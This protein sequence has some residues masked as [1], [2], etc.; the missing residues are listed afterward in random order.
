MRPVRPQ[1]PSA[2]AERLVREHAGEH[3][4]LALLV[5]AVLAQRG[6]LRALAR[7][8]AEL[9]RDGAEAWPVRRAAT[10]IL[11]H[12]LLRTDD[13][14]EWHWWMREL[15]VTGIDAHHLRAR[16][17]RLA[18]VH[19]SIATDT[20]LGDFLHIAARDC[21]LTLARYTFGAK[22]VVAQIERDLRRS[23]GL[24]SKPDYGHHLVYE[25]ADH[26]LSTLAPMDRAIIEHLG[27]DATIR[28]T[29]ER[30]SDDINT[31]VEHP[32]G[33]VV[34][35]IKPPGSDIEIEIKRAGVRESFP[36]DVVFSRGGYIVPN[37]H[38]LHG[39]SMEHLLAFETSQASVLSRLYRSVHGTDA[40][41]SRTIHLATVYTIPTP[42][43]EFDVLDYFTEPHVFGE[44][45]KAMRE[46]MNDCVAEL[47]S[48]QKK[49]REPPINELSLTLEFLGQIKPAQ[50]VQVGTT[51]FRLERL[52]AY[53]APNGDARFFGRDR[54]VDFTP[55]AARRF[56]DEILDE[57]LCVYEPPRIPYRSYASYL[58]AA[59]AV[60]AN[61][62]RAN[63]NYL[64][65]MTQFGRMWGTLLGARGHSEGESFVSRNAGLRSVFVDGE[66]QL[67]MV[68]MDHDS[69]SFASRHRNAYHPAGSVRCA[70]KDARFIFGGYSGK[71]YVRG[72]V[73]Y[74]REIFRV[75]RVTERRGMAALR[76]AMKAAYD[77]TQS[78]MRND[79]AT[80]ELFQ[81]AFM[82]KLGDWDTVVGRY[83]RTP[84]NAA[85]RNAWKSETR[86]FLAERGYTEQ[87]A[88][89]YVETI[90]KYS[91]FLRRIAF[92]F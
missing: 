30:T 78:T 58:D 17:S 47:A 65:A 21:R 80:S 19:E 77:K 26:I 39:G 48:Q 62:C 91:R 85:A 33:T 11:E 5:D 32:V 79:A 35:V 29:T 86:T 18:R 43:G 76:E 20:G 59:Y 36:F 16:M 10:L 24:R 45:Y 23:R 64:D 38:F 81:V 83:M 60:R 25:E 42:D 63:A 4:D 28:F 82:E 73:D 71:R 22:E 37:S 68:F 57:I 27:R 3:R 54:G 89:E 92:L 84:R 52:A 51:S 90:T 44:R 55:A 14:S 2:R 66:W 75:N 72:S 87:L 6:Y 31:L 8:A 7:T 67:R 61:R 49:D 12:L 1:R 53:L 50:A 41:M 9:A 74:L 13:V 34:A 46:R 69:L 15:R 88:N 70:A 56:A 40:P